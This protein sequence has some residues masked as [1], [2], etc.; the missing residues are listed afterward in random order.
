MLQKYH[1]CVTHACVIFCIFAISFIDSEDMYLPF[2]YGELATRENFIDRDE[3]RRQLKTFLTNGINVMIVSPRR[4][5]KSSL[6]KATMAELSE[7]DKSVRACFLDGFKIHSE[8]D[9]YNQFATAVI[10]SVGNTLEKG[11]E[12][13]RKYIPAI[14]PQVTIRSDGVST[15]SLDLKTRPLQRSAEEILD[16]PEKLALSHGLHVIVCIDEFQQLAFLPQ[17]KQMEGLMRSVWQQQEN[18]TYCLYGSKRH[19]MSDIFNN[20]NNPFYRFGQVLYLKK[21]A[22]EYWIPYIVNSFKSTGKTISEEFANRICDLTECHSWYVQQLSFFVWSGTRTEV[23]EQ[24]FHDQ[25]IML[26]DTNAPV[27]EADTDGLTPS[28]INMLV[29]IANGETHFSAKEVNELYSLGAPQTVSRNKKTLIRRDIIEKDGDG[30]AFVD[31]IFKYWFK[32][33]HGI[34]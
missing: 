3:D 6:V 7:E 5:G 13:A 29:A 26:L 11:I 24:I 28:Q 21:I 23:T 2:V 32:Q 4:W 14:S 9:F 25:F 10:N 12:I 18:V 19:M 20:S 8:Y 30:Y 22:R 27:F 16:L 1:A 34:A 31:P 33:G 15:I 17:W